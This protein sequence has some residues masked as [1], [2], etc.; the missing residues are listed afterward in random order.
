MPIKIPDNLPAKEI[1]EKEHIF[2]MG[3]ERAFHQDIRPLEIAILNF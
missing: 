3:E 1:L 2:V